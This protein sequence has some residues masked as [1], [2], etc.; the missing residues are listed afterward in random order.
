MPTSLVWWPTANNKYG[1]ATLH[2]DKYHISFWPNGSVSLKNKEDA[3]ERM[4]CPGSIVFAQELDKYLEGNRLPD[5]EYKL[6]NVTDSKINY[7][8]EKFLIYNDI[9]PGDVSLEK[10]G[11][12][13][14]EWKNESV[15]EN[16]VKKHDLCDLLSKELPKTKYAYAGVRVIVKP[17]PN[18]EFPKD[19]GSPHFGSPFYRFPQSCTTFCLN[20]LECADDLP[21][22]RSLLASPVPIYIIQI[23]GQGFLQYEE[24]VKRYLV[25]RQPI[26]DSSCAIL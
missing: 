20:L 16:G 1:H 11:E 17:L 13:I 25:K 10:A 15:D 12:I 8:Y 4:P 24:M 19:S 18:G 6:E 14:D 23:K 26:E 7:W 5:R 3:S 2:T 22:N 9:N 21:L